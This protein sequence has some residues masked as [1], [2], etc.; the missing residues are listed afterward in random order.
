MLL[1]LGLA[2][3][4][5]AAAAC[6]GGDDDDS[7]GDDGGKTATATA[8]ATTPADG[9][10]VSFDVSMTDNKFDPAGFTVPAGATVTF[11]L[12]NDGAAIHAMR[13]SGEDNEY[14]TDDDAVSDPDLISGGGTGTLEW[15]APDSSGEIKFQC[16]FHPTDM[17]GTITVE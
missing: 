6:G 15:T 7:G 10:E 16:D 14:N 8:E 4:L 3:L 13:V 11:N 17:L 2:A 1:T 9:G 12:T 5:L